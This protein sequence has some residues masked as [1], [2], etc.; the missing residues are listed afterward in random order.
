MNWKLANLDKAL[1]KYRINRNQIKSTHLKETIVNTYFIQKRAI[2]LYNY[3]DGIIDKIFRIILRYSML[4]PKLLYAVYKFSIKF[5]IDNF[6]FKL[7]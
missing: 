1:I 4:Y 6:K 7:Y 3:Q 2:T 5:N